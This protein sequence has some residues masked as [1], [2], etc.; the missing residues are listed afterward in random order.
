VREGHAPDE[1]AREPEA[2]QPAEEKFPAGRDP[3]DLRRALEEAT[4]MLEAQKE[5]ADRSDELLKAQLQ[6]AREESAT[7]HRRL[8]KIYDSGLWRAG[9][10][11]FG[12]LRALRNPGAT[13]ERIR[14]RRIRRGLMAGTPAEKAAR[15]PKVIADHDLTEATGVRDEYLKAISKTAFQT[16]KHRIAM[17][18]YTVDLFEGRGDVY[19]AVGLGRYLERLGYEVVYLPR[20]R[21]YEVPGGTEIYLALLDDVDLLRLPPDLTRIAWIRNRT[22][23]W[24]E[25]PSLALYDA[26]LCSSERTLTEIAKVYPGATG[27]LRIGVD[28]ELF[29]PAAPSASRHGVV[30]TVNL[31]GRER[32]L[33]RALRSCRLDFPL[34][35]YGKE[36]G[37]AEELL[38]AWKG[39]TSFFTLPSLYR[40]AAIVLD[41][42]NHT[43]QPYG[44]VNSRVY[45]CLISGSLPITNAIL[46][47][48]DIGLEDVPSYTTPEELEA[49]IGRFLA[50]PAEAQALVVKLQEVVIREHTF[51]H[52]AAQLDLFLRALDAREGTSRGIVI[53]YYPKS[54]GNPYAE[55]LYSAGTRQRVTALPI[56]D[57]ATLVRSRLVSF[58]KNLVVH[59]HWTAPILGPGL[60]PKE[61]RQ[62]GRKFLS[63]VAALQERG[64]RL[65]WTVHNVLPHECRFP[66]EEAAFRQELANRA[67]LI[68]VMCE[69]TTEL[70][71]THYTLPRNKILVVPHPG[72]VDVYPN[73]LDQDRARA[74]LGLKPEHTVFCFVGGIR[75]YKRVDALLDAFSSVAGAKPES[76]LI[77]VGPPSP[78]P[79]VEDLMD[80]CEADPRII[81]NFN[82]IPDTDL[83]LYMN[84]ADVVVLPHREVLNSGSVM[85]AFSFGRPVI[86]PARGCVAELLTPDASITFDLDDPV[87]LTQ[88]MARGDELKREH[89]RE[90]AFKKALAA[91]MSQLSEEFC[92]AVRRL[93]E[94]A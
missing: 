31:W 6:R 63:T 86:A 5:A 74:E 25:S 83:Q 64:A 37:M 69:R 70:V 20:D 48:R 89:Y 7:Y 52:R 43:T 59:V 42:Q 80:R 78:F 2:M 77:V 13:L 58:G 54:P 46:G 30:T 22:D 65:V 67:D 34:A 24:K 17:A 53:A 71:S 19:V 35:I 94:R 57:L 10:F 88:A 40:Q 68:H 18:V 14:R 16:G 49:L 15:M 28:A 45:E 23:E 1:H 27:V 36:R 29:E 8:S 82:R 93:V 61:A 9:W 85:L 92:A 81:G 12:V 4:R 39:P 87:G 50:E 41:D 21:W 51:E 56:E 90:A 38:P 91:P 73:I 3:E 47:L 84:A 44:N 55:M 72:Y 66:D 26:V 11:A 60:T 62:H 32:Q 33:F 76:R 75:P 79:E